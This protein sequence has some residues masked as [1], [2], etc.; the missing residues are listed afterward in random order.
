[1]RPPFLVD[2]AM[3]TNFSELKGSVLQDQSNVLTTIPESAEEASE[4]IK[5]PVVE[6][7]KTPMLDK[8][9][10][11]IGRQMRSAEG[12]SDVYD[13]QDE[14]NEILIWNFNNEII[15]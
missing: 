15:V 8:K 6:K 7:K 10:F 13:K 9:K 1:M 14:S 11:Y 2:E 3:T 12:K 4:E 5:A